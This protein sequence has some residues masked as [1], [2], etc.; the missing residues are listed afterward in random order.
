MRDR[1]SGSITRRP[2]GTY[3]G[4]LDLGIVDGK[5]KRVTVYGATERVVQLKIK[6]LAR[7]LDERG[8]LPT[9]DPTVEKWLTYWLDHI[10]VRRLKPN[11]FRTYKT[12]VTQYIVPSIGKRKVGRLSAAH[13]REMHDYVID[14][15]RKSPTTA[16]NAHRILSVALNDG[17]RDGRLPRN[18][19]GIV[20]APPK[21]ESSR[22][23]MEAADA[24]AVLRAG[25]D[26]RLGTRWLTALLTGM[27]Q[28]ERLGLRWSHVDLDLGA[29]DVAWALQRVNYRHGCDG[30]CGKRP[31]SCPERELAIPGHMAFVPLK[32]NLVLMRPKTAGST[33]RVALI[34]PLRVALIRRRDAYLAERE[35]Y[36]VDH[37]LVFC[38]PDGS[39]LDP[40]R[41]WADWCALLSG[42][43]L[44]HVTGHE[45][46]HTVATLLMELGY[47]SRIIED[48]LGHTQAVT[49]R[50]YQHV[51][52]A[53]Q[54]EALTGVGKRLELE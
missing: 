22:Q 20:K 33:R 52:L 5:R 35:G 21:A 14:V 44:A 19:A 18:M 54:L 36:T 43:G 38:E 37:D 23:S 50:G 41:D 25:A 17:V 31:A 29:A 15:K 32:G 47:S 34:K 3:M 7:Q 48:I 16:H 4:Q 6:G 51:S 26:D 10:A 49:S 27:R 45:T 30:T 2:N 11:T 24:I 46:R 12:A 13:I 53:L 28:G 9:S 1:G 8:D 40:R 39:P 42:A